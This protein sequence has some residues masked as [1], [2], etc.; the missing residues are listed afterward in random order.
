MASIDMILILVS[1]LLTM[2]LGAATVVG[3]TRL[4]AES[5]AGK[6]EV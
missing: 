2:A 6:D 5:P 3:L 4:H 1:W